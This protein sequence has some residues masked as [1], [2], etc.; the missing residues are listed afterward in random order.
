MKNATTL[1]LFTNPQF[2]R[3]YGEQKAWAHYSEELE[4]SQPPCLP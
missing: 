3:P 1:R 4:Q 2:P